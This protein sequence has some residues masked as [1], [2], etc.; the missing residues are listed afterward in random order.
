M[1][2]GEEGAHKNYKAQYECKSIR[3]TDN[4]TENRLG[5]KPGCENEVS[6]AS[7]LS[8]APGQLYVL[9]LTLP[10][11]CVQNVSLTVTS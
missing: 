7:S 4:I 6:L 2:I 11:F 5:T 9:L 1:D 10:C 8:F 3:E